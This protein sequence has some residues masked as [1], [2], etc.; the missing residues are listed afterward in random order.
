MGKGK[1]VVAAILLSCLFYTDRV[2]LNASARIDLVDPLWK[3]TAERPF[4]A[5]L[6]GLH[7]RFAPFYFTSGIF[8]VLKLLLAGLAQKQAIRRQP[9]LENI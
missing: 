1:Y 6:T 9:S 2:L 4:D 3:E 7:W 5:P 8:L